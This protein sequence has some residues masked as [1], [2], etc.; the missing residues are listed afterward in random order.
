LKNNSI[1]EKPVTNVVFMGMG[2]PFLNYDEV[3]KAIRLLNSP[4]A[5]NIGA[6]H[7][8]VSTVGLVPEIKK[9]SQEGWQVNLAISLHAPD[10]ELRSRLMPINNQYNLKQ[11]LAAVDDYVARTNRKVMFEYVMLRGVNDSLAQARAL[12]KLM[13]KPL[14]MVNL[15]KYNDTSVY[16]ASTDQQLKLFKA[17]LVRQGV[18]VTERFRLGRGIAAACG[19]LAGKK[20]FDR[21]SV[22][23]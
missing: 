16:Q 4:E 15:I 19:Q 3:V 2:E 17:E 11:V 7:I 13:S 23:L 8:S 21:L 5:F 12:G 22:L 1:L 9:F 10:D 6:R 18:E 14:Y 20:N